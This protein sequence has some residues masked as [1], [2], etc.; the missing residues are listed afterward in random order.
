MPRRKS[1]LGQTFGKLN[2]IDEWYEKRYGQ[3]ACKC[4]AKC[5]C[6][7]VRTYFRGH[8][9]NGSSSRCVGCQAARQRNP[10]KR[11]GTYTYSQWM[12]HTHGDRVSAWDDYEAFLNDVGEIPPD[13]RIDKRRTGRPYGRSNFRLIDRNKSSR[14]LVK[15][16][17][18]RGNEYTMFECAKLL[19]VTR[20]RVNQLLKKGTL[21]DRVSEAIRERQTSTGH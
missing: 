21:A 6:G 8:I 15:S 11:Y 13:K 2:I 3:T 14:G 19:G 1:Y 17:D 7:D 4:T 12:K 16:I 20:Q 18:V 10:E 9:V 5:T